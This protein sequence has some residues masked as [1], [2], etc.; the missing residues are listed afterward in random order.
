MHV[1]KIV[2]S[3]LWLW[4]LWSFFSV[5]WIRPLLL[6]PT[7]YNCPT[8]AA[9]LHI[10]TTNLDT[11]NDIQFRTVLA[12]QSFVYKYA[13]FLHID[14]EPATNIHHICN[15]FAVVVIVF[16]WE[17]LEVDGSMKQFVGTFQSEFT[18]C[19]ISNFFLS[20][21][22]N[23]RDSIHPLSIPWHLSLVSSSLFLILSG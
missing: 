19:E 4:L 11:M 8:C 22:F 18:I 14:L 21:L 6:D 2:P 17:V 10:G 1:L 12:I 20:A 9:V 16:F 23:S 3:L 7:I 13:V 5:C 15:R